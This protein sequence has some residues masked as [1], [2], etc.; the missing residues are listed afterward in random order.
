MTIHGMSVMKPIWLLGAVM[1]ILLWSIGSR[2][3]TST[4]TILG[5]VADASGAVIPGAK[6]TATEVQTSVSTNTSSNSLGYFEIPFLLPGNYQISVEAKG[7]RGF[8]RKG[9]VLDTDQRLEV[10]AALEPGQVQQTVTVTGE[11]PLIDTTSSSVGEVLDNNAVASLPLSNRNLLQLTGLVGGVQDRGADAAPA[12]TGAIAFGHWSANGGMS[13]TNGF[14]LDGANAQNGDNGTATIVPTIDMLAEF[15][16]DASSMNAEYGRTDGAVLTAATKSGTNSPHGTVYEYWKNRVLNANTWLNKHNGSPTSFTNVNTFGFS[17]GGPVVLPKL[18]NGRDRLFFFTNYEGYRDV[19]PASTL[20]TVPTALEA[21]GNF[22]Q[23]ATSTGVPINIYDP[24]TTALVPG[25]TT[26]YTRQ[27]FSYNGVLNVIPPNRIDPAAKAMLAYYPAPNAT[28]TNAFTQINNFFTNPSGKDSQNE[29]SVR[30]DEDLSTTKRIFVRYT[31][32]NQGGG[33]ANY[34]PNTLTCSECNTNGNPA[35]SY[36]P[37]GGG[38]ALYVIP[39]NAVAGYTWTFSPK[40]ILDFRASLNRQLLSRI[41]QSE[42]FAFS[43]INMTSPWE[44]E[45]YEPQFPPTTIANY[46]GLGT[47]SNGDV[48]RLGDTTGDIEGSMTHFKGSHTIKA[49]G[50]FRIF[51]VDGLQANNN[52]PVFSFNQTWTQQNPFTASSTAGWGLASFLLGT[53]ASGTVTLPFSTSYQ[54]F[55]D[56]G[57]VQDD[58]RASSRL[59]L[60]LGL[61]YDVETPFTVKHNASQWFSPTATS[62]LTAVDPK[63]VGG[64]IFAGVNGTSRYEAPVNWTHFAPR[65]GMAFKIREALVWRAAY[66]IFYAPFNSS[67]II[68]GI[69]VNDGYSNSTTMVTSTNGGL[70][71]ANYLSN[72]FPG[73]LAAPTGN[74]LGT[75][76]YVGQSLST[77]LRTNVRVPYIQQYNTGFEYQLKS[78]FL[79]AS[80]VGSHG[81]HQIVNGPL[82]Q[83]PDADYAMGSALNTQ[84]PNPFYGLIT[85]GT[86]STAT[87]SQGQLLKPFPQFAD[88]QDQFA[89]TGNMHFNS[90]QLKAEHRLSRG[91]SYMA[92]YTWSKNIG[93]AGDH[94]WNN[95]AVQDEYNPRAERTISPIDLPNELTV[96]WTWSLPFGQGRLIGGSM[97]HFANELASGWQITGDYAFD[98]GNPLPI[99]NSV[100]VVGFGAG[101]RP[102]WN[103]QNP[104]LSGSA[105]T[106]N[107]FFN[108]ADFSVPPSYTFGTSP[109]YLS[110]LR[111]PH[112][113]LWNTAFFKDTP[114][115]EHMRFELRGELY[116]LFNHPIWAAPGTSDGS[117]S[118]GVV[119]SKTG[120]RTGQL[121][122][123]IIF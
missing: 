35:G 79:G 47:V 36:S 28:P 9:L 38:S 90:L 83:L 30:I 62:P 118:F 33:A 121:A 91:F 103:G 112:T 104:K 66:G 122:G 78:F 10:D 48:Y 113:N 85:S 71:P 7:F 50:V 42:G 74:S 60:N 111:G 93:N 41:P 11:T 57:Y 27:Q 81:I 49:G 64:L 24:T 29:W 58:W 97:P 89:S 32:S 106:Q 99:S 102:N 109:A 110:D 65:V 95:L 114:I 69:I 40:T 115:G 45:L 101:S 16:I 6:V 5:S 98:S 87:I 105:Q 72:P 22:S 75:M 73:G 94:Y 4:G 53:P 3:Q 31:S 46:Q 67:Y 56:A 119:T 59:T 52:S 23:L 19:I 39:K 1:S 12:T 2:A 63:A 92:N 26:Q 25:S 77:Q 17:L 100:N 51:R 116:N 37:R 107:Q 55:Y 70:T 86:L 68:P 120:N 14:L 21:Q 61:R 108:T 15:K 117:S 123:K 8:V 18:L 84:V 88:I 44:N 20:L 80:Y 34:F 96:D 76:T 13:N 82:D 54:W 43:S